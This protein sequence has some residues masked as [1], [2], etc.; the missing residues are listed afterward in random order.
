MNY[1]YYEYLF[2]KLNELKNN[3]N[4][5]LLSNVNDKLL[6]RYKKTIL[7]KNV[8]YKLTVFRYCACIVYIL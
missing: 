2:S 7:N 5:Y 3:F 1:I 4:E 8:N 6:H